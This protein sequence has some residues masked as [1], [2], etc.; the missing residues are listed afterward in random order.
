MGACAMQ[1]FNN[2]TPSAWQCCKTAVAGFGITITTDSGTQTKDGFTVTWNYNSGA[3]T[4]QIQ[5][6]DSPW[7][8]PCS[9]INGKI[10]DLV[11]P[12]LSGTTSMVTS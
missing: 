9:T 11:E 7:W 2:V 8:A 1:S 10:H 4:L 6:T 3:Q 12:C 5:C